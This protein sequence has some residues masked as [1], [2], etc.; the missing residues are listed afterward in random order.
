M[1]YVF[2]TSSFRVLD[3]YFPKQFPSFWNNFNDYVLNE[4]IISV[5]DVYNELEK[6]GIKTHLEE[7]VKSNKKAFLIPDD[8]EGNFVNQIFVIP[9]FRQLIKRKQILQGRPSA[10]PFVIASAKIKNACVV[11]EETMTENAS[12][13][14]NVCEH[15][16]I[17]CTNLEGFME[18][19]NWRF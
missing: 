6:Q 14:P 18:R 1:I 4:Y 12:R 11:T 10:D 15:F 9:H 16:N 3:H 7:W 17:E 5:R 19:E 8:D 13:I 2:D